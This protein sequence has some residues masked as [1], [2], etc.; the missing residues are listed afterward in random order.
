MLDLKLYLNRKNHAGE[1]IC[2]AQNSIGQTSKQFTFIVLD[3]QITT[4]TTV[5]Y[6]NLPSTKQNCEF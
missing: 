4:T 6:E 5:G 2:S 3:Q 1:L